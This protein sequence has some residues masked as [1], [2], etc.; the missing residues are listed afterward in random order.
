[1]SASP[2]APGDGGSRTRLRAAVE[3]ILAEA[4]AAAA[5]GPLVTAALRR[6]TLP[7]RVHVL[8]IGKAAPP[9]LDAALRALD[10][11]VAGALGVAL[12]GR[13]AGALGV[14]PDL[15]PRQ[16]AG[17][18]PR[19]LR[20]EHPVPGPG[21]LAAAR[22]VLAFVEPLGPDDML[23]VLLSGG[24]SA[25]VSAPADGLTLGDVAATT[26]LL[27]AAGA[28]IHA[29]NCVRKHLDR[30]KGGR[31]ARAAAPAR[32]LCLALSDVPGD[33]PAVI[34][35][36]PLTADPT[37]F[38]DARAVLERH[39]AWPHLPAPVR[40][41]VEDARDESL[42]PGDAAFARVE[43]QL[44][45]SNAHAVDAAARAAHRLGY[46]VQTATKTLAG[47]ARVAGADVAARLLQ[48][49]PGTA[50]VL[51]GETTVTVRGT[52]RGGRNQELALAAA[53]GL[54]GATDCALGA[55]GTDGVDGAS[56][57]AGG[58]VDG[59]TVQRLRALGIDA[60]AALDRND[61]YSG[62]SAVGDAIV[63]GPTGTNVMDV[64]VAL[65][66]SLE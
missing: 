61:S 20:A 39:R 8:A 28:D 49:S 16:W 60:A 3:R 40:A 56:P 43:W 15:A 14:A 4:I 29:L 31:L 62:L 23:L 53:L 5:P 55:V 46:R 42:K 65:R 25:L 19:L 32:V 12:E 13:V 63:T 10:G 36:G 37:T 54:D 34:G 58:L 6:H 64:V 47:E 33:D 1:M 7:D 24:A 50:L 44:I 30:I 52:G 59:S 18:A 27:L 35:S 11:R 17:Y 2:G 41:H 48:F 57:A 38:A 66:G 9:M 21:S 22:A 26:R 45:G 51:G